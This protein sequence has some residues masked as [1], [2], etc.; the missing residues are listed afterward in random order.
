MRGAKLSSS[1]PLAKRICIPA[2]CASVPWHRRTGSHKPAVR[3]RL[4]TAPHTAPAVPNRRQAQVDYDYPNVHAGSCLRWPE[5]MTIV[6][7]SC[8]GP[9]ARLAAPETRCVAHLCTPTAHGVCVCWSPIK[10]V[11][12]GAECW[13]LMSGKPDFWRPCVLPMVLSALITRHLQQDL[14]LDLLLNLKCCSLI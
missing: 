14:L 5:V 3:C 4:T 1:H 8:P 7:L 10:V 13:R 2:S 11:C 12:G 9:A 6:P